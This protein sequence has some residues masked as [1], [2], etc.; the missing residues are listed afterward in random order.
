MACRVGA[1]GE[2]VN[3]ASYYFTGIGVEVVLKK[4]GIL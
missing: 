4:G 3:T 1:V 2:E